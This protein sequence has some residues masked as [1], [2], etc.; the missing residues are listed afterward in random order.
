MKKKKLPK[1]I[2]EKFKKQQFKIGDIVKWEFL[3]ESGWGVGK[4]I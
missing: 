1:Y 4:K 2:Q 3:G